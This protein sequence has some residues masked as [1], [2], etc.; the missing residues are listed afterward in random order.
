[1]FCTAIRVR[2][3]VKTAAEICDGDEFPGSY[4]LTS[5]KYL[6]MSVLSMIM[7]SYTR[8]TELI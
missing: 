1:M 6:L 4:V 8:I 7:P 2:V 3:L 5:M